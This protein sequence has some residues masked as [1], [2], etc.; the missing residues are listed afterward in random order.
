VP[1]Y[2]QDWAEPQGDEVLLRAALRYL[3]PRQG[4]LVAGDVLL[5]RMREGSIAKTR[6]LSQLLFTL[7]VVIRSQKARLANL[8]NVASRLILHFHWEFNHGYNP[9][10][11][12]W[13][14]AGVFYWWFNPRAVDVR[15]W[16]VCGCDGG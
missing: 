9:F 14:V 5:F 8:G 3:L 12:G 6:V 7:I 4:G 13:C 15:G 1:A 16:A 11:C 10:V 2:S